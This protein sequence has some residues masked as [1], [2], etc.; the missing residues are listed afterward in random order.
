MAAETITEYYLNLWRSI[1]LNVENYK[2]V[3][4]F[5]SIITELISQFETAKK[6]NKTSKSY[7][8]YHC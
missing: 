3:F 1:D 4:L 7:M 8:Y 5:F 6:M 2:V